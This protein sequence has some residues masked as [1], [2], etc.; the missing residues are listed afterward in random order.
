MARV[1]RR[2]GILGGTFDPIHHGHL[3]AAEAARHQ[4]GL[5]QVLFVPAG[6]PPHKPSQPVSAAEHRLR[7]VELGIRDKAYFAVS[8][9][10][11]D[12]HGPC[13]TVDTLQLL[14]T[15]WGTERGFFFI[16]GADSFAEILTWHQPQRLIELCELAVV[17]RPGV[18]IDVTRLEQHLPGLADR[19]HHVSMP[20]LEI[21]SSDVRARVRSGRP[22]SYLVPLEVE[23][24]IVAQR[25][26]RDESKP[27]ERPAF[28]AQRRRNPDY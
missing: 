15:E 27:A 7:M 26:Y 25:L 18:E 13:Y 1:I 3:F 24:Y 14:R 11:V 20:C 28:G 5:D 19:V 10:D 22:I 17:G 21:S 6:S 9:V 23:A 8:R 2:L 4:L 12:R 16:E